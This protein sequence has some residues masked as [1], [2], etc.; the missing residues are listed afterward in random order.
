[1]RHGDRK[2]LAGSLSAIEAVSRE[3]VRRRESAWCREL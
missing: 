3:L 1:M 2:E